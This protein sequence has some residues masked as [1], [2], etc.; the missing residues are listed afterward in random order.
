MNHDDHKITTSQTIGPFSHEGWQWAV[1]FCADTQLET[2][3]PT[4]TVRGTVYD[5]DGNPIDDAQIEAWL[6]EAAAAEAPRQSRASAVRRPASRANS[7]CACR[8]PR[9]PPANRSPT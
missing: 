5:G 4:L 6:P 9:V 3:A 7:A 1:D 8:C 2:S